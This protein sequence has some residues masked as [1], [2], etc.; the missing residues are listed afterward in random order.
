[1]DMYQVA[2]SSIQTIGVPIVG[3][4]TFGRNNKISDR[5]VY[6]MYESDGWMVGYAGYQKVLE[7]VNSSNQFVEGR[8]IFV[9]SRSVLVVAVVNSSVW[10]IDDQIG[11]SLIGTIETS[12]GPVYIDENLNGQIA[13]VDGIN[14]YIYNKFNNSLTKQTG[15]LYNTLIP[16]YVRFH[17]T[18]FL[19]GNGNLTSNGAKFYALSYT[20]DETVDVAIG[21]ELA[22]ET[23]P[24]YALAAVPLSEKGNNILVFGKTVTE[25]QNNSPLTKGAQVLLYQRVSTINISYGVAS[26]ET[27]DSTDGMVCW[28]AINKSSPPVIMYFDGNSHHTIS[29][30]GINYLLGKLVN[31]RQSFGFFFKRDGHLFYQITFYSA[32]DNMSL[33]YDFTTDKFYNLSN[34][35]MNYHPARNLIYFNNRSYFISIKD[36]AIYETNTDITTYDENIV[37][38]THRNYNPV[39]N[40]LIPRQII[41]DTYR[42]GKISTKPFYVRRFSLLMEQGEDLSYTELFYESDNFLPILTEEGERMVTEN[43]DSYLVVEGSGNNN[44]GSGAVQFNRPAQYTPGADFSYSRDGASTWSYE[45]RRPLNFTGKRQ[46]IVKWLQLG[47]MNEMTPKLKFWSY[48]RVIVGNA[49]IEVA[50]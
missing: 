37:R 2:V 12:T 36:G 43:R 44:S 25:I 45:V 42:L 31:P 6:N 32:E 16:N 11:K 34:Y 50:I 29:T 49:E 21:G 19:V 10:K 8:R 20:T 28:L 18:Y 23:A 27:I 26:L 30:D 38:R 5:R 13:I 47:R 7:L 3:S 41:G 35:D 39:K 14:L 17:N 24:D 15:S 1:M 9:S 22:L 40:H 33:A 48:Y 4:S 46:N